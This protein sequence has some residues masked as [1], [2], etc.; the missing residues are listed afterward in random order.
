MKFSYSA[1]DAT[2][3]I[4]KGV[5]EAAN[6]KEAT[7]L[8]IDQGWYIKKIIPRGGLRTGW[9]DF[10]LGGVSLLDKVLLAKHLLT[11]L[12]S[13]ININEA[14]EVIANQSNSKKFK[15]VVGKIV[16]KVKTGQSLANAMA[17]FP[18]IFDPLM[19]N[20]IR[21]G[22][23]SGTLEE[24][25]QYLADELEDRL[26]IRRSI[27][28]AAFYPSVILSAT[29]GL[30]LVLS[31]FVL[32]K[33]TR[34]FKSLNFE[35]PL[36]TK[37]L[38]WAANFMDQYGLHLIVGIIVGLIAL[39]LLI[40]LKVFKPIWHGFLLKVPI[41]NDII[42]NY[43][44]VLISR[45][46]GIL[47][48]SGLTIDQAVNIAVQTT[49]N[50]VYKKRLQLSLPQIQKGKR[51]SDILA[52]F[53]QSKRAPLFPLLLI[54][55]INIGERSGRLE[56]S[57]SYLASYFQKEVDNTTKNLTIVLEPILL[58]IVGLVVG[59]VAVS[60]ISP[61]YQVTGQFRQ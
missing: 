18:K 32:P 61:I 19:I 60:V 44:L 55:M 54:K 57:L 10:T 30:G 7:R 46:L 26:E 20:I 40:T 34:L 48:K 6:L 52:S 47:L 37:I 24:N 11:M 28:T 31:Y 21:V 59:F 45:T 5:I 42:I 35:L 16:E 53:H 15:I 14:L 36:S 17:A 22:E 50:F 1:I 23:E 56:E 33:I 3:K 12:K 4:K 9:H 58:I 25:L 8:L 43:N 2:S 41:I 38:L 49:N 39:R 13:G 29:F 51:F 27:Q